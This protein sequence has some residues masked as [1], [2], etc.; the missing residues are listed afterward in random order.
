MKSGAY[1]LLMLVPQWGLCQTVINGGRRITGSWDASAAASTK[2][3]R[4]GSSLP[5]SC[6]VGEQFFKMGAL[7]G[8]SLYLCSTANTWTPAAGSTFYHQYAAARCQGVT[9]ST[10]FSLPSGSAAPAAACV[11]GAN[12]PATI[13]GVLQFADSAT[14]AVQDHFMLPSDWVS[15]IDLDITWRSAVADAN[16]RVV[17]Q[18]QT[19]CAG[20]GDI[21]DGPAWST[22]QTVTATNRATANQISTTTLA[23]LTASGCAGGKELFFRLFR[24]PAQAS[25]DLSAT[26]ELL[27]IRFVIRRA[28]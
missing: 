28:P 14:Q 13:L 3:A 17:W 8:Q 24:D 1:L 16:R 9:A 10:T 19:L 5:A 18:V 21:V 4:T 20:A 2:P 27:A 7:G 12:S 6:T 11:T 26:A 25:D 23:G 15:P 22:A